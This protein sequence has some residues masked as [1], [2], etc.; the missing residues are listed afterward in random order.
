MNKTTEFF[1]N[2]SQCS[3]PN[4]V[5][6]RRL[7]V[8]FDYLSSLINQGEYVE[9][10]NI[11]V[12]LGR[13]FHMDSDMKYLLAYLQACRHLFASN[14]NAAKQH[15]DFAMD[16]VP[17]TMNP[18]Y[19]TVELYTAKTRI[20]LTQKK[21]KKLQDTLDEVKQVRDLRDKFRISRVL[22]T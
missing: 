1:R 21:F 17:K 18:K 2:P 16:I 12:T 8:A 13:K 20:Y 5:S 10:E 9:F 14:I 4:K 19:A 3:E 15:I 7:F 22:I 11:T 6:S